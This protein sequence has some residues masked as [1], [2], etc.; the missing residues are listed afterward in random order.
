MSEKL[1]AGGN[2]GGAVTSEGPKSPEVRMRAAGQGGGREAAGSVR[3]DKREEEM[4]PP[5]V[6]Q[7]LDRLHFI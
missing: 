6:V 1:P 5:V 7:Q 2:N 4:R 3:P